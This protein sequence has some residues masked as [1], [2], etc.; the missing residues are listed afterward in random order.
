[1]AIT[2]DRPLARRIHLHRC[3]TDTMEDGSGIASL[4]AAASRALR[5]RA[6]PQ[7]RST[8]PVRLS[9]RRHLA[10]LGAWRPPRRRLHSHLLRH[11]HPRFA[12][13]ACRLSHRRARTLKS[14][15]QRERAITRGWKRTWGGLV[16]AIQPRSAPARGRCSSPEAVVTSPDLGQPLIRAL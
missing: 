16:S 13:E 1:M 9:T 2:R 4:F 5:H 14:R 6:Q 3:S 15:H 8:Y 7:H 12:H 11:L 10:F